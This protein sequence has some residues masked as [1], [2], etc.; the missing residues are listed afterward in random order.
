MMML[1]LARTCQIENQH[2]SCQV[3]SE[4]SEQQWKFES[5][6]EGKAASWAELILGKRALDGHWVS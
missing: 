1:A 5:E 6:L 4:L 2:N 3:Q